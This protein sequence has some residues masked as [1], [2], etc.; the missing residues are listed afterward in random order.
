MKIP[1]MSPDLTLLFI[2]LRDTQIPLSAAKL[3]KKLGTYPATNTRRVKTLE[4][5]HF[6]VIS[7]HVREGKRGF[8]SLAWRIENEQ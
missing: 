8:P 4:K 5:L 3:A 2:T 7:T 6:R 1:E